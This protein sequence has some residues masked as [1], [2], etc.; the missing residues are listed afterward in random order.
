M[1]IRCANIFGTAFFCAAAMLGWRMDT[2]A[3]SDYPNRPVRLVVGFSP[4]SSTD[5]SA[6]IL[7]P[8][9]AELWGQPVV[10]E[11]RSGAGGSIASVLVAQATP[12]GYTALLPASKARMWRSRG[13]RKF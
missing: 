11:N 12:D 13:N 10:I 7:A 4:G 5:T 1:A 3:Q 8:K 9:L 6:R 2:W